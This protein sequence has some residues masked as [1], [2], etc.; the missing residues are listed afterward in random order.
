M[1]FN[2]GDIAKSNIG[3][4][5]TITYIFKKIRDFRIKCNE[6]YYFFYNILNLVLY[7]V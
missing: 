2:I 6:L 7:L 3:T 5:L 1:E 4:K